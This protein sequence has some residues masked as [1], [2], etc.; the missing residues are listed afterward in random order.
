MPRLRPRVVTVLDA[1][2]NLKRTAYAERGEGAVNTKEDKYL[3]KLI[4]YI[5]GE[6]IAIH[7]ALAGF[8][9]AANAALVGWL[10][11][12]LLPISVWWFYFGTREKSEAPSWAQLILCP[13]A[14]AVWMLVV[15]SEA[16]SVLFSEQILTP[17]QGSLILIFATGIMPIVE[18]LIVLIQ[19]RLQ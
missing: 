6:A 18:K 3:A 19:R 10:S 12:A 17:S 11:L 1:E 15:R 13:I 16:V 2:M 9:S 4:K 8:N 5:P 7:Q 14:F